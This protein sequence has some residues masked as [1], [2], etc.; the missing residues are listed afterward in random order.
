VNAVRTGQSP[1]V[2][3]AAGRDAIAVAELIVERMEEHA[4]D[5]TT[6]GRHGAF[7]MPALPIIAGTT[8]QTDQRERRR[9]G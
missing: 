1:R 4:W 8:H 5:G 2:D 7:A 9:A 6:A 3:G